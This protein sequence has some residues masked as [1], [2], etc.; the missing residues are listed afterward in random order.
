MTGAPL[1]SEPQS[2]IPAVPRARRRW[3]RWIGF[4]LSLFA[5]TGFIG[6]EVFARRW[7]QL[8]DPPL[9]QPD[10][11]MRYLMVPSRTYARLGNSI[12]YNRF[13]MRGTPD[14]PADRT[15]PNELR[16]FVLG[17]SV[18]NGGSF[19][20]DRILATK[21]LQDQLR[22]DL[23]KPVLVMNAS[24][25]SWGP[26]QELAYLKRF[27]LFGADVLVVVLNLEDA[28]DDAKP[29]P[30]SSEQP[31]RS[32]VLALEEVL[33]R[34]GPSA[35]NYY[36]M[37]G[38]SAPP[39]PMEFST[40]QEASLQALREIVALG[41]LK[42][43]RVVGVLHYSRTELADGI[44]PGLAA[45]RQQFRELNVPVVETA[46]AFREADRRGDAPYRDEIHPSPRGQMA[47]L[48]VLRAAVDSAR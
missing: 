29:R 30:L 31:T 43:A 14:F 17:D 41:R 15:D 2:P 9:F 37:G 34:Y 22:D 28:F 4:T 45:L 18:V 23:K 32:P 40:V 27:G 25:G 38:K 19:T 46:T 1:Q 21:L 39:P 12:S 16:V 35:W 47:L 44:K 3:L 10:P 48:Q 26:P 6:A 8:G 7:L 24:A 5:L 13:S 36:V 33:L 42:G 20:D 11:D